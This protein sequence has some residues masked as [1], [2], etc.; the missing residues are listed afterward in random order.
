LYCVVGRLQGGVRL[1]FVVTKISITKIIFYF[2]L[3]LLS[4][5]AIG[6]LSKYYFTKYEEDEENKTHY[7]IYKF[8]F[9]W[10]AAM[11]LVFAILMLYFG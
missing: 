6:Y 11:Y 1:D 10:W 8:L 5:I 9:K 2:V 7:E 4:H 3:Y